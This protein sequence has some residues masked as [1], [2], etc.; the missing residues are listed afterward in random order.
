M[1][2]LFTQVGFQHVALVGLG[3]KGKAQVALKLA[4]TVK[5][6]HA[7]YSV[8]WLT[9]A[10]IDEFRNSCKELTLA[11]GINTSDSD[12]PRMLVKNYLDANMCGIWLLILDNAD[13][14]GIFDA[15]DKESRISTFLPQ[16]KEERIISTTRS[17]KVSWLAVE[18]DS[19]ELEELSPQDLPTILMRSVEGLNNE[20]HLRDEP[21][22]KNLL[23]ELYHLPLAV[24]QAADYV[25][26]N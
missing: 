23:D 20:S 21:S 17:K 25:A 9:A 11:L 19:L 6:K 14:T 5:A 8:F 16:S 13:D 3:G 12:D 2:A 22:I 18:R 24:A 15:V 1:S 26:V 7:E 10:S 4:Y